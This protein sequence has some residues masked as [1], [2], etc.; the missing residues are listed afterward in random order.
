MHLRSA[1]LNKAGPDSSSDSAQTGTDSDPNMAEG[2]IP[3]SPTIPEGVNL[4]D[5]PDRKLLL[6]ILDNQRSADKKSEERFTSLR[7]QIKESKKSL[8]NYSK[9]NDA[10]IQRVETTVSTTV[11]DLKTLQEKVIALES[12]LDIATNLL[13]AT[14]LK[15]D[16][17]LQDI[18]VNADLIG[19]HERKYE[20]EEE[21]IKRCSLILD[22]VNE[23]DNKKPRLVISSLLK[24]LN[25]DFKDSDIKAAYRLGPV[26]NG[27]A[28]P[29]SI[30]VL[31]ATMTTK[32]NIFKNIEKLRQND[33]WKGVR[34]SDA[35]SP[36]E[37]S[38][39]RDLRCI[40][41]AAKSQGLNVKLRGNNLIIDDI[42]YSY[43]DIDSLPH[44]LTMESVKILI[45]ADGLAFQ[46][47][48]AYLSNMFICNIK[49]NGVNYKSAEHFYSVEMAQ[50]HNRPDLVQ[51]IL[52]AKDGYAAKRIVRGI[53]ADEKW[54]QVKFEV[55]KK[56]ITKKFDQND[57]IRDK[58]LNTKGNLYE[59]TKSDLDFA[60]G[61]T[62]SQ[63][64]EIKRDNLKGKNKLG[65]IL[66]EYRDNIV[67]N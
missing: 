10:R 2:G 30:K 53:K 47:H 35:I 65:E 13:D 54:Q 32:G 62:L 37:Q 34:L 56:I 18:K 61:Y 63:T 7:K 21:E 33:S 67:A 49:D 50:H 64:K 60:C 55:M 43:K 31:F 59:A 23:R 42:K 16:G 9:I 6:Q 66:C 22:G 25:V 40:F 29:R 14:K 57:N 5:L 3:T 1:K 12:N 26:R 28:R 39:Q 27:V 48:H 15:L 24:D 46:S 4:E 20:R 36:Q 38:Q 8:E 51:P 11:S 45:I 58:L 52:D 19:K 44:G 17:A 41:A